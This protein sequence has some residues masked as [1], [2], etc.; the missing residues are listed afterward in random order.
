MKKRFLLI[1]FLSVF[2]TVAVAQDA[3]IPGAVTFTKTKDE[4]PQVQKEQKEE[5]KEF[6]VEVP[7][8]DRDAIMARTVEKIPLL[9]NPRIVKKGYGRLKGMQK[10]IEDVQQ[11]R[12]KEGSYPNEQAKEQALKE[13]QDKALIRF[14][15]EYQDK[16]NDLKNK[17]NQN[18]RE[19]FLKMAGNV[20]YPNEEQMT[21]ERSELIQK[22]V[23]SEFQDTHG[24]T[25]D[26]YKDAF[27]EQMKIEAEQQEEE[28]SDVFPVLKTD[29]KVEVE[30]VDE[31]NA[32][33]HVSVGAPK[34]KKE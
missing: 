33:L 8:I 17:I 16:Q 3:T 26:E 10:A 6:A 5:R 12:L 21:T 9:E 27:T 29:K 32:L 13:M 11:K 34:S 28:K 15:D 7:K 18:P 1:A 30:K 20:K 19:S 24:I 14:E 2:A 22:K 31:Q 23:E 25:M 4:T